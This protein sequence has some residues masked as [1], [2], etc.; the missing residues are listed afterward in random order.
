MPSRDPNGLLVL[1]PCLEY[2]SRLCIKGLDG[3]TVAAG[4]DQAAVRSDVTAMSDVVD[5]EAADG[6]E[7]FAGLGGE[8]LDAVT[9]C[10]G[11]GFGGTW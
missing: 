2:S 3:A 4:D 1:T 10:N 6:L 7:E 8:D 11:E 5:T 9:A